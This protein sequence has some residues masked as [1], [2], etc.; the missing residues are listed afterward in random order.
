VKHITLKEQ[1]AMYVYKKSSGMARENVGYDTIRLQVFN[2][3]VKKLMDSQL[4]LPHGIRNKR[5]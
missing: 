5:K 3:T 1:N 2:I 4:S